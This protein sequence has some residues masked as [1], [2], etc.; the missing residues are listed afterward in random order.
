MLPVIAIKLQ[1]A[2]HPHNYALLAA[3]SY[4]QYLSG[5]IT[6]A[7]NSLE[8]AVRCA[9]GN[10]NAWLNLSECIGQQANMVRHGRYINQMGMDQQAYC[11]KLYMEQLPVVLRAAELDRL[12]YPAWL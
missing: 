2:R 11:E 4:V 1:L 8:R 9:T 12:Y 7:R 5:S 3:E 6:G 10:S